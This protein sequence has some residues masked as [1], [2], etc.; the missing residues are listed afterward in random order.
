MSNPI[1]DI[2]A[3]FEEILAADPM[4]A[5]IPLLTEKIEDIENKIDQAVNRINGIATLIMAPVAK[6]PP[7]RQNQPAYFDPITI[8]VRTFENPTLN[9]TGFAC[10]DVTLQAIALLHG[11]T[12]AANILEC[13]VSEG[14]R[15]GLNPYRYDAIFTTRGG[16]KVNSPAMPVVSDP[17]VTSDGHGNVTITQATPGAST[18]YTVGAAPAGSANYPNPR[19]GTLYTGPFSASMPSLVKARSWLPGYVPSKYVKTQLNA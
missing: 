19:Q 7:A 8:L 18:W 5:S 11:C 16:I 13:V 4:W 15:L 2:Q 9:S 17:V 6:I 12:P 3:Q 10:L 14:Y 1:T